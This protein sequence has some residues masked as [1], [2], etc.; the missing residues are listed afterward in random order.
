MPNPY[1]LLGQ[2][3]HSLSKQK[4]VDLMALLIIRQQLTP[5]DER[6]LERNPT[7]PM[8]LRNLKI[9]DRPR[10][11]PKMAGVTYFRYGAQRADPI[12]PSAEGA[13]MVYLLALHLN[14]NFGITKII[15]GGLN[16]GSGRQVVD[17][18]T[19]GRAIDFYGAET[20]SGLSYDVQ[21]DWWNA[22]LI[23]KDATN[24]VAVAGDNWG[25]VTD[26]YFR[27]AQPLNPMALLHG[28]F[29]SKV[30][31]FAWTHMT[32]GANDISPADFR[33]GAPLKK[34]KIFHPDYPLAG[35]WGAREQPGIPARR[36]I[37]GRRTHAAHMHFG[38]GPDFGRY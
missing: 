7:D 20:A 25:D 16:A 2:P 31:E 32:T 8:Q 4:A 10:L 35:A 12:Q 36:A 13:L 33:R 5:V 3:L 38:I 6:L 15:Y 30:Y 17:S 27:L 11:K 22:K 26:T 21:R 24:Y 1:E 28:H 18:H 23:P 19:E 9:G 29:F 34:G 14:V 37:P